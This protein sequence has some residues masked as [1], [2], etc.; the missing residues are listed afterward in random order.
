MY[1]VLST[2]SEWTTKH[3]HLYNITGKAKNTY[4]S[5]MGI[6]YDI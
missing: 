2:Y 5:K 3:K 1:F 4:Y 6:V